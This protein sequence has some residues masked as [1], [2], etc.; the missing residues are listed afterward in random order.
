MVFA[1]LQRTYEIMAS[2]LHPK[3]TLTVVFLIK[4]QRRKN[5]RIVKIVVIETGDKRVNG[6]EG[7]CIGEVLRRIGLWLKN[8]VI[9][10]A[11]RNKCKEKCD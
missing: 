8:I 4:L 7:F 1:E 9:M 5:Y 6:V 11:T 10:V 2:S 3:V